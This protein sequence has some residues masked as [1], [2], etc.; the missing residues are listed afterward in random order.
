[1]TSEKIDKYIE[2][3]KQLM[4]M[5]ERGDIE[6]LLD[7][8]DALWYSMSPEEVAEADRRLSQG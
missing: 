5:D 2:M 6:A 3:S 7:K 8:M 4:P 1:M